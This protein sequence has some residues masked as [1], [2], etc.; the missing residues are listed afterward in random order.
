PVP[1]D[2]QFLD[3]L[4]EF[5]FDAFQLDVD[6]VNDKEK[7]HDRHPEE[8]AQTG[9]LTA[10]E[11]DDVLDDRGKQRDHD[12]HRP[13]HRPKEKY[14]QRFGTGSEFNV[15]FSE[16]DD[17]ENYSEDLG[18]ENEHFRFASST[19]RKVRGSG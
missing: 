17:G 1:S 3:C 15:A 13:R 8:C 4:G 19:A 9:I 2:R 11:A 12:N 7:E 6:P 16:D 18:Y 10:R 14:L 5:L